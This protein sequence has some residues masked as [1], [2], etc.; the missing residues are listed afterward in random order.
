MIFISFNINGLRAHLH[1]LDAI[2]NKYNPDVIGL[3]ETKVDDSMFPLNF[4]LNNYKYYVYFYGQKKYYGVAFLCKE[5]PIFIQKGFITD[6]KNSEKRIIILKLMTSKGI[7]TIINCYVPQGENCNNI[8]KFSKKKIFYKKIN[9]YINNNC[10][11]ESFCIIMGDMNIAPSNLDIGIGKKNYINWLNSGKCSFL[12]KERK[13]INKLF[14]LGFIDVYRKIHPFIKNKYSWFDYRSNGFIK[15][16]GLRIDLFLVS[17][18]LY[19]YINYSD[20]DYS[21]REMN[22]PSDHAPIWVKFN[23]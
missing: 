14:S 3:Q 6:N 10:F 12:P 5:K 21:I 20:I 13:W 7:I 8:I 19:K 17:N 9:N 23:I 22:K 1:Q 11:N 16:K 2:I 18:N 4:I 15:N